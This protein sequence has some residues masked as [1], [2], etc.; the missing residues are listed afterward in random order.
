MMLSLLPLLLI[1]AA[2][3][4]AGAEA[5]MDPPAD[6]DPPFDWLLSGGTVVDGTGAPAR[7]ADV[8]LRGGRIVHVGPVDADTLDV[9]NRFDATGLVIAPGFI[10]AH[11]HGDPAS[12]ARFP[13][14]LAQGV[15]TL[16]LGQDGGGPAGAGVGEALAAAERAAPWV[17]VVYLVGHNTVRRESGV[18]YG[19]ADAAGLERMAALVA[20]GLDAGAFGLSTGL[21]YDPGVQSDLD[22]L[23]AITAP[24]AARGGVVMSHMRSEDEDR[25]EASIAELIEQGRRSGA[26]VHASHLK[27]V[28][29]RDPAR[30]DR[31]LQ[32]MARA[33]DEGIAVT[34]DVYPYTASYTGLAIL[35]PEWARPPHDYATV[36]RERRAEL[37]AHLRSRVESRHGPEATLIGTGEWRGRT[38][39]EAAEA[40]GRPYED[41]LI[42][43]G[44]GGASAAYF[45]MDEAV[46]A[47]FL[48]DPWVVVSSDGSPTMLH[49]RG[50]GAFARVL[51]RHVEE[52][53][54]LTLEEAVRAMSGLT[55]TIVGLDDPERVDTPRGQIRAGWAADLVVF[56]PSEVRDR[57]TYE[58]PHQ[59]ATG[60]R[61]VWVAG[62]LAWR[63]DE[64]FGDTG[65]GAAL[66]SRAPSP[67]ASE[68]ER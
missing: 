4:P 42:D 46:M 14:A 26:R 44:P 34:G 64:P 1:V 51:R 56:R 23:A 60:M 9:R 30:A 25:V 50:Y 15:T 6:P 8:L 7:A 61:G 37:A 39:A 35:F 3:S 45:V 57:A 43:L 20:E 59:L 58:D 38:L 41:I 40:L 19:E 27:V 18:G 66:R 62:H 21:E 24:V 11:A 49:P 33:R 48:Q 5:P 52:E 68:R 2:P 47:R 28:L 12:D 10:D 16:V 63:D 22:E 55:A 53:G 32:A 13:N 65:H 31:V 67:T 29:G 36:V 54:L 17:N